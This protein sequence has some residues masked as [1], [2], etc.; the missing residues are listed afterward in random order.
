MVLHKTSNKGA[1]K[2]IFLEIPVEKNLPKFD[3]GQLL[4]G[5]L[6]LE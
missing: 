1:L 5:S 4:I 2:T 6:L 3:S